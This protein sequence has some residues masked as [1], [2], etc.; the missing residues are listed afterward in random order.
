M[1]TREWRLGSTYPLFPCIPRIP[2]LKKSVVKK[3]CGQ[4]RPPWFP[5]ASID[6]LR[7]FARIGVE[8]G[9]GLSLHS[10]VCFQPKS[11]G[12]SFGMC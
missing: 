7:S 11:T 5:F 6:V 9:N 10:A 3:I 2:W 8:L 4:T 1:K 12:S